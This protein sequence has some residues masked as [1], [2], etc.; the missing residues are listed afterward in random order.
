[1]KKCIYLH[2]KKLFLLKWFE[3]VKAYENFK[4]QK[5]EI[6]KNTSEIKWRSFNGR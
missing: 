4:N 3:F 1:M 5:H 2:L 6:Q